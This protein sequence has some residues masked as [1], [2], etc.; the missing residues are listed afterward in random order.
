MKLP[1]AVV[2]RAILK[3]G[4]SGMLSLFILR[5]QPKEKRLQK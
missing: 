5:N 4:G 2:K 1:E 3:P